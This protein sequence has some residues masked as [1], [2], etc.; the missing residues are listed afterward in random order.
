NGSVIGFDGS[1]MNGR[2]EIEATLGPIFADHPT[3]T[4][5]SKVR[6][7]RLLAPTV[8]LL[9][10]AVGMVPPGQSQINPAVN[11]IQSLVAV[12]EGD[13]WSIAL[14]HN[15]PAQFHGRPHLVEEMTAELQALV[16]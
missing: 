11:A 12:K 1:L 16:A 6:E 3:A 2:A 8:A 14:Y 10:A 7:V 15:T 4:Y 5:V 9:R 13:R